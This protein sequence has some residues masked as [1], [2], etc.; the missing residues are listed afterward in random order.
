MPS[1]KYVQP[2]LN[3][4]IM[5][6]N[7]TVIYQDFLNK[8]NRSTEGTIEALKASNTQTDNNVYYV[9][10]NTLNEI[11]LII[12]NYDIDVALRGD[13][14]NIDEIN[15]LKG[16][17]RNVSQ[18]VIN[19]YEEAFNELTTYITSLQNL[20][21]LN[22]DK[23]K[24]TYNQLSLIYTAAFKDIP[25]YKANTFSTI[26][27]RDKLEDANKIINRTIEKIFTINNEKNFIIEN[28]INSNNEITFLSTEIIA[29]LFK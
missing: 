19:N 11:N 21:N 22:L 14:T 9:F 12:G 8:L 4:F 28:A 1:K 20:E 3:K 25:F 10:S 13:I 16:I 27:T 5:D 7:D 29:L 23:K 18:G 15:R 24:S 26:T 17:I 6:K 2:Y